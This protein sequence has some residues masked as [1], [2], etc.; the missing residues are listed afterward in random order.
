LRPLNLQVMHNHTTLSYSRHQQ[1]L[2]S[3]LNQ[4]LTV[5]NH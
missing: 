3:H 4:L 2:E 1:Y 5:P